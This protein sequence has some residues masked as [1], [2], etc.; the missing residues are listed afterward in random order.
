MPTNWSRLF[1]PDSMSVPAAA[2]AGPRPPL[3]PP[4]NPPFTAP[5]RNMTPPPGMSSGVP[6]DI[7]PG[8]API[9]ARQPGQAPAPAPVPAPM[10]APGAIDAPLPPRRPPAAGG[11]LPG[12][13]RLPDGSIGVDIG[14]GLALPVY[15]SE[16]AGA[17]SPPDRYI[18]YGRQPAWVPRIFR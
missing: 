1:I 16:G 3:N 7:A 4:L 2:L 17:E 13:V 8:P 6:L 5:S 11:L 15:S 10:P 18:A 14:D 9:M 12:Q